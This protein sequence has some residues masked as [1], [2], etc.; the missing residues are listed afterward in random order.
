MTTQAGSNPGG[1]AL[2]GVVRT[3]ITPNLAEA[4][5]EHI[6]LGA[7]IGI[8]NPINAQLGNR[9]LFLVQ[10]NGFAINWGSAFATSY[11]PP[12]GTTIAMEYYFDGSKWWLLYH[13]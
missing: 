5:T 6:A 1:V 8:A 7:S 3:M 4:A 11:Q 12:A 10:S 9:L 2:R 13:S